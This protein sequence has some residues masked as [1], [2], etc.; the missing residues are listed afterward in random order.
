MADLST[1]YLGIPLKNPIIVGSCSLTSSLKDIVEL[2]ENGAGAVVLKSIFEE[3]ILL[4]ADYDVK[5]AKNNSMIYSNL[6]ETMDYVDVHLKEKRLGEYLKLIRDAKKET[7]IPII[8]SVNCVTGGE[9]ADFAKKIEEAGADALELNIFTNPGDVK[10][11]TTLNETL[12]ILSKI[13]K[14]VSLPV[15]VK[16]SY[17][18]T[19]LLEDIIK[20]S[21][22]GIA[23]L[24]LFNKN[25]LPDV[26]IQNCKITEGQILSTQD[27]YRI[28]LRWIS[29]LSGQVGCSLAASTGIQYGNAAIKQILAGADAVQ[30]VSTLY[31]NGKKHIHQMIGEISDWMDNKGFFT[32]EQFKGKAAYTEATPSAVYE[33]I[34]IMKKYGRI[35]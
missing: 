31:L 10:E 27:D 8:A 29:M 5:K 15:T 14:K 26:D 32:L 19:N 28:P 22:S 30:V 34:Q 33:R 17:C 1:Q 13:L 11:K 18:Y 12:K 2:E 21:G 35:G 6:S 16:L 4:E 20:I 23:G 9:W 3:E 7:S 25:Y 24:V